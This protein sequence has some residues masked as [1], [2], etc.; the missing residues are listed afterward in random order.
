M[1]EL[2][3]IARIRLLLGMGL[4]GVAAIIEFAVFA[5]A[6]DGD[7]EPDNNPGW[8]SVGVAIVPCWLAA[9]VLLIWGKQRTVYGVY[10]YGALLLVAF[11]FIAAVVTQVGNCTA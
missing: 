11:V 3:R 8:A 6:T 4:L 9:F 2:S 7:C 1:S 5:I 10:R